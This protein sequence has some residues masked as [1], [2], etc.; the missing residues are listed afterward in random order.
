MNVRYTGTVNCILYAVYHIRDVREEKKETVC[1]S[2]Y[3]FHMRS[4]G[5]LYEFC[6]EFFNRHGES[7][8]EEMEVVK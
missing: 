8:L 1:I 5:L 7:M 2:F 3:I 6:A 4:K